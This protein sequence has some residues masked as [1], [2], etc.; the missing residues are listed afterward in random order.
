MVVLRS[1]FQTELSLSDQIDECRA[2]AGIRVRG[3]DVVTRT[4]DG[5]LS[6]SRTNAWSKGSNTVQPGL[7]NLWDYLE[8]SPLRTS[9]YVDL[10]QNTM[11]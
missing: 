11:K 10:M 9:E 5:C 4:G 6:W 3:G 1:S 2:H 7:M 8:L